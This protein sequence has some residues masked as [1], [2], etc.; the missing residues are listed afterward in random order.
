[1]KGRYGCGAA[2]TLIAH[3][4]DLCFDKSTMDCILHAPNGTDMVSTMLEEVSQVLSNGLYQ[5]SVDIVG[6]SMDLTS[7]ICCSKVGR[8]LSL[9]GIYVMI[10]QLN[11][12]EEED[13]SFLTDVI[14]HS[15][16][17]GDNDADWSCTA[18]CG[19]AFPLRVYV[20][21]KLKRHVTRR[22]LHETAQ[23]QGQGQKHIRGN[24]N[25]AFIS[26]SYD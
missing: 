12:E 13:A 6:F 2:K 26:L 18:H 23:G 11:H 22:R 1:M 20:I 21:Q 7:R 10:S 5:F 3:S 19:K 8:C 16:N 14:F 25:I 9:D 24:V 4:V 15:L 17:R